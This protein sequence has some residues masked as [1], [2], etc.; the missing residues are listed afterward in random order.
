MRFQLKLAVLA[1]MV[2]G[3]AYLGT[4]AAKDDEIKDVKGCMAFQ[5]KVRK[6]VPELL[7]AKDPNWE[8]VQKQTKD[9]VAMAE[10]LGKQKPP[11]GSDESW[12]KQT[13]KYLGLVK[14]V[15]AAAHK[16][17]LDGMKKGLGTVG[18]A[19]G[20]CHSQHKPAKGK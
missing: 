2:L 13:D 17:D 3:V 8:E 11:K 18:M 1:A 14:D 16:K 12:K 4:A 20:G 19:C 15:D 5:G 9:W 10:T 7:K 6:D